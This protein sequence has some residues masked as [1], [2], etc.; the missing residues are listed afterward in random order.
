MLSLL[1]AGR[2][3]TSSAQDPGRGTLAVP[4]AGSLGAAPTFMIL[5]AYFTPVALCTPMRT[6]AYPPVPNVWPSWY[7]SSNGRNMLFTVVRFCTPPPSPNPPHKVSG[8]RCFA[9]A[10]MPRDAPLLSTSNIRQDSPRHCRLTAVLLRRRSLRELVT[11]RGTS[12]GT[13]LQGAGGEHTARAVGRAL[14]SIAGPLH[15]CD[16]HT[17]T[18]RAR[19]GRCEMKYLADLVQGGGGAHAAHAAERGGLSG[20]TVVPALV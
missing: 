12:R 2:C 20:A 17:A 9:R 6:T 7:S 8:P 4:R 18:T 13:Y 3:S 19:K 1:R 5:T 14:H 10:C 15:R 16:S 11:S